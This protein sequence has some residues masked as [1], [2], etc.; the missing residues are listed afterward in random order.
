M[1]HDSSCSSNI[2]LPSEKE[3]LRSIANLAK[4]I[5]RSYYPGI[6]SETQ[7]EYML[8]FMYDLDVMEQE[9]RRGINYDRLLVDEELTGFA[10]YGA[11]DAEAEIK[12]HKLYVHPSLHRRGLGSLVLRHV[13]K[14]ARESQNRTLILSVNKTN[15]QAIAAYERNGFVV[16]R[17]VVVDIG[18]GFVMDDYVMEKEI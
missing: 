17:S 11:S 10:S 3:H 6:I 5:W 18:G 7:I 1:N 4:I 13:E 15:R 2:V 12:L 9:L 8:A 14:V 16:R